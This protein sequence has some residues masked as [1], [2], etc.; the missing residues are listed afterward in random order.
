M[1][2]EI[3]LKREIWNSLLHILIGGVFVYAIVP[4][5][6]LIVLLA[7]ACIIGLARELLQYLR[8]K[9]QPLL[10]HIIDVAGF[11]FGGL[12]WYWIREIFNINAD[13]L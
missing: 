5:Y 4:T 3:R 7:V 1:K 12:T 2:Y 9:K 10:I 13:V 6:D 11:I 8:K